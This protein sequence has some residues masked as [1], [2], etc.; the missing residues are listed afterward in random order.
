[1]RPGVGEGMEGRG[2]LAGGRAVVGVGVTRAGAGVKVEGGEVREGG[3][4]VLAQ[5][6]R[7][8]GEEGG[9]GEE[10]AGDGGGRTAVL[11]RLCCR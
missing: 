4:G 3:G 2:G 10:A 8:V 5:A 11:G 9:V 7:V 6:V 1:M